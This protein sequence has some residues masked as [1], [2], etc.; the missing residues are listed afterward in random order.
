MSK[1][2]KENASTLPK[3]VKVRSTC[4]ACQQAKIRCSHEKP[5]CRRCQKHKIDCVYSMSRRLGRPAKKGDSQSRL[6][7]SGASPVRQQQAVD[8]QDLERKTTKATRR[9]CHQESTETGIQAPNRAMKRVSKGMGNKVPTSIVSDDISMLDVDIASE[10]WLQ[11]LMS[12]Q[13]NEPVLNNIDTGY[14][15]NNIDLDDLTD[16]FNNTK[17]PGPFVDYSGTDPFLSSIMTVPEP[18]TVHPVASNCLTGFEGLQDQAIILSGSQDMAFFSS[19]YTSS[20]DSRQQ[21]QSQ[22]DLSAMS[23]VPSSRTLMDSY[24]HKSPFE[25]PENSIYSS[26]NIDTELVPETPK[27]CSCTPDTWS[28]GE[29]VRAGLK[30]SKD[31]TNID[32]LLAY[33]KELQRQAELVLRCRVCSKTESRANLLM[34]I[35]VSIDSHLTM[36]EATATSAKSFL[37]E[38]Q[39]LSNLQCGARKQRNVQNSVDLHMETCPLLVGNFQVP[40]EDKTWFIR[41][42]LQTRLSMLLSTI[43]RI[44]VYT[45]DFFTATPYRG[46]LMMIMETDR[47][48]QLILMKVRM[49]TG[50]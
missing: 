11:E 10:V 35:I 46:R 42:M 34:V 28:I 41:C 1:S 2:S 30:P 44:R 7:E 50:R 4:N 16:P 43:R 48:L 18:A 39:V 9:K 45:Q 29:L 27:G 13:L 37:Q 38:G 8:Y 47:R 14:D 3:S 24:N 26:E 23:G 40:I 32:S 33:Q 31:E 20:V 12:T 21:M 17:Y 5:T 6:E 15:N 25:S 19:S 36:L 22:S 49:V